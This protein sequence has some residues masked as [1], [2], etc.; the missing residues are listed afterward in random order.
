MAKELHLPWLVWRVSE[1]IHTPVGYAHSISQSTNL[2]LAPSKILARVCKILLP[3]CIM[4][5]HSGSLGVGRGCVPEEKTTHSAF[6]PHPLPHSQSYPTAATKAKHGRPQLTFQ[7]TSG[8]RRTIW[9]KFDWGPINT[10][11]FFLSFWMEAAA[12]ATFVTKIYEWSEYSQFTFVWLLSVCLEP[13]DDW[14]KYDILFCT[15][16]STLCNILKIILSI[17]R[18]KKYD[19]SLL[20]ACVISKVLRQFIW[21]DTWEQFL[22]ILPTVDKTLA[23]QERLSKVHASC[24]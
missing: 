20:N 11:I 3:W 23:F 22:D 24:M 1:Q 8:L 5:K 7:H 18:R 13:K 10:G 15:W 16:N 6:L 4:G 19:V 2:L 17:I 21:W 12:Y 9:S 14:M